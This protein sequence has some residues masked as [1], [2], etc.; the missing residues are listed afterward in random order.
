M[1]QDGEESL[2][3][4]ECLYKLIILLRLPRHLAWSGVR[5][6][7]QDECHGINRIVRSRSKLAGSSAS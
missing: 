5:Q 2:M 7:L 6:S 1:T 4:E 3:R